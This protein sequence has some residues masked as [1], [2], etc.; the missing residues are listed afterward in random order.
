MYK[1]SECEGTLEKMDER[2]S[3]KKFKTIDA[4]IAAVNLAAMGSAIGSTRSSRDEMLLEKKLDDLGTKIE[5]LEQQVKS[6]QPPLGEQKIS[7][8]AANSAEPDKKPE[9][10]QQAKNQDVIYVRKSTEFSFY[11]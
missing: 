10:V 7:V 9:G 1:R 6:L 3:Q 8:A 5:R 11:S 2:S 4:V